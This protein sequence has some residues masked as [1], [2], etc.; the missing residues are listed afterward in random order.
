MTPLTKNKPRQDVLHSQNCRPQD[1]SSSAGEDSSN[2]DE[3]I[4]STAD[5]I[6][7]SKRSHTGT[8]EDEAKI[9]KEELTRHETTNVLRLRALVIF[10]L[11][12]VA[13]TVCYIIY[14]IT[15]K[16]EIEAFE[17]EFDGVAESIITSLNGTY[18]DM[19]AK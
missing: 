1:D 2:I 15:H 3:D 5:S 18:T 7:K 9:I 13:A 14:D 17:T 4:S 19:V 10:V 16:S 6:S 11:V 8:V 12:T